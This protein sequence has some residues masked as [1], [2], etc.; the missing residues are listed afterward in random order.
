M[1]SNLKRS[2]LEIVA[3]KEDV[4]RAWMIAIGQAHSDKGPL[5]V[6]DTFPCHR[7]ALRFFCMRRLV[8]FLLD[9]VIRQ[10]AWRAQISPE[11]G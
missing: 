4:D 2:S 3:L 9:A 5:G 6:I 1:W 11:E 8:C 10:G 7:S